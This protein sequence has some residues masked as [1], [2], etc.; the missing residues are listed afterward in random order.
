LGRDV[1]GFNPVQQDGER[2]A[3]TLG[4]LLHEEVGFVAC[5]VFAQLDSTTWRIGR[6]LQG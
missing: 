6:M 3:E 5:E 4:D 2:K 1:T